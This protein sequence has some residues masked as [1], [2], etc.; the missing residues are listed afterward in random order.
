MIEYENLIRVNQP[1]LEEFITVFNNVLESGWFVL[2]KNVEEFEKVY[3]YQRFIPL[4]IFSRLL[5]Y[6]TISN[7]EREFFLLIFV[8]YR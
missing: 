8:N 2:G 7:V 5:K 1:Y 3:L 4:T 6:L